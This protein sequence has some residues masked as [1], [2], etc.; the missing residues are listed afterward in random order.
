MYFIGVP[1]D[2]EQHIYI[3]DYHSTFR[4][5]GQESVKNY[6]MV[7]DPINAKPFSYIGQA[8]EFIDTIVTSEFCEKRHIDK[9]KLKIFHMVKKCVPM[10]AQE[11]QEVHNKEEVLYR[12]LQDSMQGLQEYGA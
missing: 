1:G 11:C 2:N 3:G 9:S 8:K 5:K 10:T 4:N 12:N 6:P 7:S